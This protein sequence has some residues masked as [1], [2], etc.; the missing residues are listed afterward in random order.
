MGRK[1]PPVHWC[2]SAFAA[3]R[4]ADGVLTSESGL[5][6]YLRRAPDTGRDVNNPKTVATGDPP[7]QL[8]AGTETS[9]LL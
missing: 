2:S 8:A 5:R 9:Q 7:A 4:R 3:G 6:T 1:V